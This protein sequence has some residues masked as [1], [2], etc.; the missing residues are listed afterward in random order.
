MFFNPRRHKAHSI[1][2]SQLYINCKS[3][4]I[5]FSNLHQQKQ[6]RQSRPKNMYIN[7]IV[8]QTRLVEEIRGLNGLYSNFNLSKTQTQQQTTLTTRNYHVSELLLSEQNIVQSQGGSK[9]CRNYYAN[10][11]DY[12]RPA[13]I[14]VSEPERVRCS[15]PPVP[16]L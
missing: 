7:F 11:T 5:N 4:L 2:L 16:A 10:A 8:N 15:V 9:R 14:Q 6:T 3:Y 12:M 13:T 1:T